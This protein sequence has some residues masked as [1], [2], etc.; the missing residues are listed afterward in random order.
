MNS[1]PAGQRVVAIFEDDNPRSLAGNPAVS[2]SIERPAGE[3]GIAAPMTHLAQKTHADQAQR[4][5]FRVRAAGNHDVGA[6][7][8]DDS[9]GLAERDVACSLGLG[10]RV[11]RSLAVVQDRDVAREHVGEIFQEPGRLDFFDPFAAVDGEVEL[12]GR[13][14]RDVDP[15][16]QFVEFG[17]DQAL[18]RGRGRCGWDRPGRFRPNRRL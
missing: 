14:E 15:L 6:V 13:S 17:G 4:V 11:A 5:D 8:G 9:R 12:I 7:S 1:D 2:T 10:D 16:G 18:R 3:S